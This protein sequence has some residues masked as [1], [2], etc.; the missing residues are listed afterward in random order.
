MYWAI[1][2]FFVLRYALNS[3]LLMTTPSDWE[4]VAAWGQGRSRKDGQPQ[5]LASKLLDFFAQAGCCRWLGRRV[6]H[7]ERCHGAVGG[8]VEVDPV[9]DQ[10]PPH[11]PLA[12]RPVGEGRSSDGVCRGGVAPRSRRTSTAGSATASSTRLDSPRCAEG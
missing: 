9:F 10:G 6:G 12:A 7:R 3:E 1:A 8:D 4:A 2:Y 5:P 11:A